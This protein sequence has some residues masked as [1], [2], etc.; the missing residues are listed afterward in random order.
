[1]LSNFV[2]YHSFSH[3]CRYNSLSDFRRLMPKLLDADNMSCYVEHYRL[4]N[5][6]GI[7]DIPDN[8]VAFVLLFS[9][10]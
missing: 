5:S 4:S 7:V 9:Y 10:I 3:Q 1:M 2:K 6:L 8:S